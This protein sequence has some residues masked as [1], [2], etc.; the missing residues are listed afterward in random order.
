MNSATVSCC[1]V[2]Q[3][4]RIPATP[5]SGPHVRTIRRATDGQTDRH[6][7]GQTVVSSGCHDSY[8]VGHLEGV[9]DLEV[10][11]GHVLL[12]RQLLGPVM[13]G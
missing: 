2:S 6:T 8:R 7:D 13:H 9:H 1:V 11:V 4:P 12:R 3:R 10:G 5:A